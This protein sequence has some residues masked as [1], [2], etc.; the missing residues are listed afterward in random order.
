[1]NDNEFWKDMKDY[2]STLPH[3]I[4]VEKTIVVIDEKGDKTIETHL[5]LVDD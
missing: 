5:L 2:L 4:E 3:G 1:M